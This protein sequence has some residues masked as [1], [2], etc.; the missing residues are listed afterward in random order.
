MQTNRKRVCD[1]IGHPQSWSDDLGQAVGP[2]DF[3]GATI[4]QVIAVGNEVAV[5]TTGGRC[6]STFSVFNIEDADLRDRVVRALRPGLNVY[7]AAAAEI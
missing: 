1:V 5:C 2:P 4:S 7:E 6:G 3:Q